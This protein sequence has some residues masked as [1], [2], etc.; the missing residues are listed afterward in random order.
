MKLSEF[1]DQKHVLV[2]FRA[3]DKQHL[4]E[5]LTQRAASELSLDEH[6]ILQE[7]WKREVLG[8]TGLG[9]GFALPHARIKTLQRPFALFARLARPIEFEAVD[10]Q[11]VD[12]VVLLLTPPGADSEHLAMLAAVSRPLRDD[13]FRQRIRHAPDA[14]AAY[15]L[16]SDV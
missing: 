5:Q 1:I 10:G 2:G 3:P 16:L 4:L 6:V 13:V 15:K 12:L 11:P 9:K 8:S 14:V 7:L